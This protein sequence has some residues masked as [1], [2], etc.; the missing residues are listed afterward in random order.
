MYF[1]VQQLREMIQEIYGINKTAETI[2]S[3]F[4]RNAKKGTHYNQAD[5]GKKFKIT[6]AGKDL[7]FSHLELEKQRKENRKHH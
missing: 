3:W 7:Y 1:N 4:K 5:I 6:S 2:Y